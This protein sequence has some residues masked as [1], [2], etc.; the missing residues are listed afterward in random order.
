M[1]RREDNSNTESTYL[2]K[3]GLEDCVLGDVQVVSLCLHLTEYGS[4]AISI[5]YGK[6]YR[7]QMLVLRIQ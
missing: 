2:V 4:Q 6:L 3:S 5:R 1:D 7:A